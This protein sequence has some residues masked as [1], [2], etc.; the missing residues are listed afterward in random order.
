[1]PFH[2]SSPRASY[3]ESKVNIVH[4]NI[5]PAYL[6]YF[7]HLIE[8]GASKQLPDDKASFEVKVIFS[9]RNAFDLLKEVES[10][11]LEYK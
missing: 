2:W 7:A 10:I 1:M 6:N 4:T 11:V 8:I 9:D 3:K 5:R